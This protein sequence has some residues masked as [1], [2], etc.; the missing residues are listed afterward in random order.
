[1]QTTSFNPRWQ[2]DREHI[3]S[4]HHAH[5]DHI[6]SL[7]SALAQQPGNPHGIVIEHVGP[8]R[9]LL[10]TGNRWENRAIFH[11]DETHAQID[12]VLGHFDK[13]RANC[14]IEIN[15]ANSYVNPPADWEARLLPHLLARGCKPGGM[16]CVWYC[17]KPAI[18]TTKAECEVLRFSGDQIRDYAK[19]AASVNPAEQWTEE[20]MQVESRAG[21][22][23]YIGFD[24]KREPRAA[25]SMF[26]K[27]KTAYLC[28][29][30]TG[31]DHRNQGFQQAG[32]R[33]RVADAFDLGCELVFSVSDYNFASPRNLQRCGFGLAYNYLVVSKKPSV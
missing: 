15:I 5:A 29:W 6:E 32:I 7:Y 28:Y 19:L 21:L 33:G 26:I 10:A 2:H 11:G 22:F 30:E 12:Q 16:R 27:D 4:L 8:V 24:R 23:H 17:D 14:V 1:M 18:E 9:T 13:H 31:A 3:R 20:R 25:G